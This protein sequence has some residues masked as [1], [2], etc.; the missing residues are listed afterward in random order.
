M[1][2]G[3]TNIEIPPLCEAFEFEFESGH[4]SKGV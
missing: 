4:S 3:F 2:H 1:M